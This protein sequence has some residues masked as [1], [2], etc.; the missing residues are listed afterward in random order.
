[1]KNRL[2]TKT[3]KVDIYLSVWTEQYFV[4][5]EDY[6]IN[7]LTPKEAYQN[8]ID[9]FEEQNCNAIYSPEDVELNEYGCDFNSLGDVFHVYNDVSDEET[10]IHFGGV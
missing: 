7:G 4:V 9:D 8:L 1:M 3:I 5:P 6:Q 10:T 2:K